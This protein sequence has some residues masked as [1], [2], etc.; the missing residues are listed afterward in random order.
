MRYDIAI[1]TVSTNKL[2]EEC[3][4]SVRQLIDA[5][6]LKVGFVLVD[7]GSTAFDAHVLVQTHV[8]EA[9]VVL[10]QKNHGFG[11]S[12]NRGAAEIEADYYFFLN[13]DTCVKDLQLLSRLHGFMQAHPKV[14]IAT[15]KILYMDGRVQE[16]CRRFPRWYM[17]IAQRTRFLPSA[18]VER[19]RQQFLMEDFPHDRRRMVD[20]V[21]GS[22]FMIDAVLFAELGG[23]DD[24]FWMYFEDIDLCRRAWLAGRPVYYLPEVELFHAYGKESDQG[25]GV[26]GNVLKNNK[27]RTHILSWLKYSWKWMGEKV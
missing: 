26:L 15:P 5:T 3:L 14:G 10:R 11:R 8:P 19:H 22:A 2:F 6:P 12:C 18:F 9:T 27:A 17:P 25:A 13:P 7:N 21:Q 20:W 23:F 24:R 4:S 1:I 16:T